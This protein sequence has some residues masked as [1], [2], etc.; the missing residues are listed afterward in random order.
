MGIDTVKV[1]QPFREGICELHSKS[2]NAITYRYEEPYI[3]IEAVHPH[4]C[5]SNAVWNG[6]VIEAAT[7]FINYRVPLSYEND[8]PLVEYKELIQDRQL[9][10]QHTIGLMTA[11]KLSHAAIAEFNCEQFAMSVM[12]T[13]GT[14]NAAR[15]GAARNTYSGYTAGTI[16]IFVFIDARVK[17]AAIVN[18]FMTATEAKSAALADLNIVEQNNGLI[19][20][21]TTTDALVI[22]VSQQ[23]DY[24]DEYIYAGT[25]TDIGCKLAELV[26]S[27]VYE[28]VRTQA[29]TSFEQS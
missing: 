7:H 8:E 5:M 29:H 15:A 16:N 28:C 24:A 10:P 2:C 20:T 13:A 3:V 14:S 26:Y 11:A 21:G 4:E 27:A 22:A 6:G 9:T 25:A 19:A 17:Q 23:A 18:A 1:S 12:V